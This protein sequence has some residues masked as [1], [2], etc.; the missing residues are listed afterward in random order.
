VR[1]YSEAINL[2]PGKEGLPALYSNR[3]LA[4][5]KAQRYGE[6]LADAEAAS[7]LAPAWHKAHWR[8]AAALAALKRAP[9][10]ADA[11][12][13]AWRAAAPEAQS[14]AESRLWGAVQR[15]TREQLGRGILALV[16]QLEGQ[17]A[18]QAPRVEAVT[19]DELAEGMYV[20]L[21]EAHYRKPRPGVFYK[22]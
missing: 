19:E 17:G 8:R 7:S 1:R 5:F 16:A 12:H 20:V 11:F 3:S 2:Q 9:E 18:V 6:A 22:R 14:E 15:L 4:Y 21:K 13:A 10:A